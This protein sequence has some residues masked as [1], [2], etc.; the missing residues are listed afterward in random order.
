MWS[1]TSGVGA[2]PQRLVVDDL[3]GLH[4]DLQMPAEGVHAFRQRLDHV[5]G[6]GRDI[7]SAER[8]ADAANPAVIEDLQFGLRDGRMDDGDTAR[9]ARELGDGIERHVVVGEVGPWLHDD[10]ACGADPLLQQA[11]FLHA[12]IRDGAARSRGLR[13]AGDIVDVVVAVA[14]AGRRLDLRRVGAGGVRHLLGEAF[15]DRRS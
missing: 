5:E 11:E 4:V 1:N 6:G 13:K 15:P 9:I 3:M 2:V 7:G 10:A 8:K 12:R 14:G